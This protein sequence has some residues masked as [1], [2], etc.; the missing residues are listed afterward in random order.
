VDSGRNKAAI[1]TIVCISAILMMLSLAAAPALAQEPVNVFQVDTYTKQIDAGATSAFKWIV[2]NNGTSPRLIQASAAPSISQD[3][4]ESFDHPFIALNQS[5]SQTFTL[6]VTTAREMATTNVTYSVTFSATD[7][8]NPANVTTLTV[9]AYLNVQSTF[10]KLAGQNKV[11]GIWQNPLPPPLDSNV[12][13][14][15]VTLVG[16]ILIALAFVFIVDP[17]VHYV[18]RKTDTDLDDII[19]RI[20]RMPIFAF[21]II[22]GSVSSLEI[23]SLPR[24]LLAQIEMAYN[25]AFILLAVWVAYKVYDNIVLHYAKVYSSKTDTEIDDVLVPLMEK[26][27]IIIIPLL[28]L[29]AILGMFGYDVTALLAGVGFLGIVIGFAA[30]S[31]LANFFAGIQLLADRPFKVGDL[32]EIDNGD[33]CEVTKVGMRATELYNPDTGETVVIPNNDMA[34]KKIVNL[35]EP[36]RKL[37]VMVQVTAA[38][39][40]DVDLVMQV[41]RDT[42]REH[43]N[44]LLDPE[45]QP[46]VRFSDFGDS[47]LVFKTFMWID[48]VKN[49]YK[50][51]SDF[52]QAINN[53]FAALGIEIPFPQTV[54][55]LKSEKETK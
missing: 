45:H 37:V 7:M 4:S 42:A 28:G 6:T 5:Q 29:I 3:V 51:P 52:R 23:L 38:Y 27:G 10:G 30:Q 11:F 1:A 46:V 15:V 40:S 50:V 14:F 41:L 21:I 33:L 17:L 19:L 31:T 2:F 22:Y 34:N 49:R 25:V 24:D 20:T 9:T 53:K 8:N 47:A 39:G 43:P 36:D 18:T 26:I 13:A 12:G 54:V 35:V 16:W 55:Q 32:L 44:V 48:D